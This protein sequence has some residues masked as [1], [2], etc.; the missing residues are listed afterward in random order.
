MALYDILI[1]N[2][3]CPHCKINQEFESEVFF[4]SSNL[5]T[6]KLGEFIINN[7]KNKLEKNFVSEGYCVC[8][9]CSKDFFITVFVE[10]EVIKRMEINMNKKGYIND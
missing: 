9:A 7:T 5:F 10:N 1:I 2:I 3:T 8:T 6:Y 4:P